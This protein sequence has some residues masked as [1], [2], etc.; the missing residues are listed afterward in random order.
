MKEK[1]GNNIKAR[2]S[3]NGNPQREHIVKKVVAVP[4]VACESVFITS[5][6]DANESRKVVTIN[7]PGAFLHTY[8]ED[9]VV[10]KMVGMLA[11]LMVKTNQN[12]TGNTM[13]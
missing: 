5:T 1:K 11:E 7:I 3:A 12:Y 9:Y 6:I 13:Y 8:N 2:S 4:T 10:M